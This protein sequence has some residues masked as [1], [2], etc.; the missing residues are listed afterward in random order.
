MPY[1]SVDFVSHFGRS[2]EA[3]AYGAGMRL[4]LMVGG[5]VAAAFLTGC[6]SGG[7]GAGTL[8]CAWLAGP[9]NCWSN[10]ALKAT[11]CLPPENDSGTFSTGACIYPG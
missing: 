8:T 11:T 6:G 3:Q 10:T 2:L 4:W 5:H 1:F 9:D 7:G